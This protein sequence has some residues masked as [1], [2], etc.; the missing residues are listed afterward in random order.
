MTG[1]SIHYLCQE[2]LQHNK[3]PTLRALSIPEVASDALAAALQYNTSLERLLMEGRGSMHTFYLDLNRGGRR[4]VQ[5][6]GIDAGNDCAGP[7]YQ[8]VSASLWPLVLNRAMHHKTDKFYY[9][10]ERRHLDVLYCLLR[11]RILLEL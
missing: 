6:D 1:R 8:N 3:I 10:G 7:R 4:L 11:N 5:L 2:G 9:G